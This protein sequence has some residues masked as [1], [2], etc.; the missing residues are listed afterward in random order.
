MPTTPLS[1]F[2]TAK[3]VPSTPWWPRMRFSIPLLLI[4]HL[5]FSV[6]ESCG[7]DIEDPTPPS[8]PVW[9]QKS[10]PEEWPET[11]V[12]AHES[13]GIYLEWMP[14]PEDNIRAYYIFR[15]E[16]FDQ[17]DSIG[18]YELLKRIDTE[19]D[20]DLN[21]L[22]SNA[23]LRKKYSY[24]LKAE[25]SS[26]NLS[27][28]SDSIKYSLLPA[29]SATGMMPNG[30][31]DTLNSVRGLSWNYDHH[32]EMEDYCLTI[33]TENN[34]YIWRAVLRPSN[35]INGTESSHIPETVV[36]YSGHIYKWRI[37]TGAKYVN[38][39]ETSGSESPWA[40]FLFVSD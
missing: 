4:Y 3:T 27:G 38:G 25:D 1:P 15:A 28:F 34:D 17:K 29:L 30:S 13:G 18:N 9:V 16:Y 26:D 14:N 5:S 12:D 37:D 21:Y 24:K 22:N 31:G 6:F 32:V 2:Q 20:D 23:L 19:S 35:Y 8:P 33:L 11:G 36:L 39:F 40:T 7:L 10:S